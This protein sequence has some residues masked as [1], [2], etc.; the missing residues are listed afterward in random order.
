MLGI[1]ESAER[2]GEHCRIIKQA[3]HE[4]RGE[5]I[6]ERFSGFGQLPQHGGNG[7]AHNGSYLLANN[8]S[9]FNLALIR[10]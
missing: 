3:H 9:A 6:A 8:R 4:I 10:V 2:Q 5:T 7:V 1:V